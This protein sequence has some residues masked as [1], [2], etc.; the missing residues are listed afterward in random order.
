M[1]SYLVAALMMIM[2]FGQASAANFAPVATPAIMGL[3]VTQDRGGVV[4]ISACGDRLCAQIAGVVLDNPDDAMPVDYRGVS[5][6]HLPLITDATRVGADLW[7]GHITDPRTGV[8]YGVELRPGGDNTLHLR[9]F[10]GIPLLGRT[11]V[12]TRYMGSVPADCRMTTV[13]RAIERSVTA[14]ASK[15]PTG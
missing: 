11:E 12:W 9:G 3:W 2:A 15:A 13:D 7:K 6:C 1:K 8:V 10:L 14:G 4:A 5:Q